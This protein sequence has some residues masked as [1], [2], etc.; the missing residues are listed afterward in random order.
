[1]EGWLVER[2]QTVA[3]A[4]VQG[5]PSFAG[6]RRRQTPRC[7]NA[8]RFAPIR[9]RRQRKT[10]ESDSARPWRGLLTRHLPWRALET[11]AEEDC[12]A[13]NTFRRVGTAR[14]CR[15]RTYRSDPKSAAR[16]RTLLAPLPFRGFAR[17]NAFRPKRPNRWAPRGGRVTRLQPAFQSGR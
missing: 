5:S 11:A 1:M 10:R 7:R 2:S 14:T 16:D 8:V 6:T 12:S 3:A 9:N 15:P 13:P 4:L 17:R